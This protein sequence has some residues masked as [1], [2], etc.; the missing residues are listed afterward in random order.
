MIKWFSSTILTR[1]KSH[2]LALQISLW[3]VLNRVF[4]NLDITKILSMIHNCSMHQNRAGFLRAAL[5]EFR[6][7]RSITIVTT[8]DIVT[9]SQL[10]SLNK[11]YH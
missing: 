4:C 3:T 5:K 7:Q 8:I 2:K 9:L 1:I 6:F 11:K 10:K